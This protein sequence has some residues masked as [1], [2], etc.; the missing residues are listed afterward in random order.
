MNN[1]K[2]YNLLLGLVESMNEFFEECKKYYGNHT[3]N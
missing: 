3:G 1:T 2:E